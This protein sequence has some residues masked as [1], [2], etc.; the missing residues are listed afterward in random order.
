[1]L[2]FKISIKIYCIVLWFDGFLQ[3]ESFRPKE[4]HTALICDEMAIT[5]GL[6]FNNS[7]EKNVSKPTLYA[8]KA[9]DNANVVATYG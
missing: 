4:R 7:L 1:M 5:R 8:P 6:Q 2:K 9:T 3:T